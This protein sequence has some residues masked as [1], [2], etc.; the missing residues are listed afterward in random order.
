MYPC[1][2]NIPALECI[3]VFVVVVVVLKSVTLTFIL[4][5]LLETSHQL[6]GRGIKFQLSGVRTNKELR[7]YLLS[8]H[9]G[10]VESMW[11]LKADRHCT[12]ILFLLLISCVTLGKPSLFSEPLFP[13]VYIGNSN[14]FLL[15]GYPKAIPN[16]LS[17]WI[18]PH[19][20]KRLIHLQLSLQLRM[21]ICLSY[22]PWKIT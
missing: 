1:F 4:H 10:T 2:W 12:Q 17:F 15:K 22:G 16:L 8:H 21:A 20:L 13:N 18:P 5:Y 19:R 7:I 11:T 3:L 14:T 9:N 6:K